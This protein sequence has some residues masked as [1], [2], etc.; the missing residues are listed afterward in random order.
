[1]SVDDLLITGC[2]KKVIND[3]KSIMIK[4]FEMTDSGLMS[5]FLGIEMK[6]DKNGI[7]ITQKRYAENILK[8][9][10]MK[11]SKEINTPIARGTKLSKNDTGKKVNSTLFKSL[12]G[13]V[14][15]LTVS[16]PDIMYGVGLISRY[17]KNPM[18]SHWQ[19]AKRILRYVK[20]LRPDI[21][22]L[23]VGY[24]LPTLKDVE[25]KALLLEK[26]LQRT[27]SASAISEPSRTQAPPSQSSSGG[28]SGRRDN[29]KSRNGGARQKDGGRP[30]RPQPK[31]MKCDYCGG[32]HR[33]NRCRWES[34]ACFECGSFEH[35]IA[36]CPVKKQ[37]R[38]ANHEQGA[39][40][41]TSGMTPQRVR[42]CKGGADVLTGIL[43]FS[44]IYAYTLFDSG[45]MHSFISSKVVL[46]YGLTHLPLGCDLWVDTPVG[47][48]RV[49]RV[50]KSCP[51]EVNG[52]VLPADL[53]VIDMKEFDVILGMDWLTTHGA[54]IDCSGRKVV[55]CTSYG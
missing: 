40:A 7:F 30:P 18:E 11:N 41:S 26:E 46:N 38:D 24:E 27:H 14:R 48:V 49:C 5:Y 6:Q 15:Y 28:A 45:A 55:F 36:N 47:G 25:N 21:R 17:M 19:V 31:D 23:V 43:H 54:T 53:I 33:T 51:I 20:G 37:K 12:V 9:F 13:S 22:Q 44:A 42:M 4:E 8:K 34:G 10:K 3:F 32:P 2:S 16:R 1:M 52:H 50:C 35:K 29:R 39:G